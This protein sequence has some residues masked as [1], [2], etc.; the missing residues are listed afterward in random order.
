MKKIILLFILLLSLCCLATNLRRVKHDDSFYNYD[1]FSMARIPLINPIEVHRPNS[2]SPW[3]MGLHPAI[4]IVDFP[5]NQGIH[6]PY[7]RVEELEK[8]AVENGVI[9]AYSSHVDQ[10][11]DAYIQ[12]NFYHWF[13]LVPDKEITKGFHTEDAFREYIETLGVEDPDWQIP[14]EAQK[15]FRKTGCLEWIPDCK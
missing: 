9:M 3:S 4:W 15:Q 5:N 12:D 6:Y 8:F 11:A 14:S 2:S 7:G 13:V 10:E 1:D